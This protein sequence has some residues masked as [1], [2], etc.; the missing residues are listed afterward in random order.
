VP[1]KQTGSVIVRVEFDSG[2]L[3][4][5]MR[6]QRVMP[7]ERKWQPGAALHLAAQARGHRRSGEPRDGAQNLGCSQI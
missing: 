6:A 7:V 2:P 4:G 5:L 1:E 3:A